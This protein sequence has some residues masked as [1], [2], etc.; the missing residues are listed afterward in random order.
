[1][2]DEHIDLISDPETE[3]NEGQHE[4]EQLSELEQLRIDLDESK[5][6]SLRA[7]ADLENFRARTNRQAAEERKYANLDLMRELLPVWDNI[8]RALEAVD[9]T[10]HLES[11]VEGV[12][13]V[14]QQFLDILT[15]FH[16]EKIDA[17]YK[18]FD[19]NFHASVA[20]IPNEEHPV[21]TIIEEVQTGFRLHDRVVRPSQ[22]VLSAGKPP[23]TSDLN[24]SSVTE[25]E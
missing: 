5:N 13:L 1:M 25:T 8:G 12:Q 11:L 19:P 7:L 9:K 10:H 21:N 20:Q 24:P 22:V 2:T 17:K 3:P 14:Y 6:R 4:N 16:C 23:S 18:A 15:R